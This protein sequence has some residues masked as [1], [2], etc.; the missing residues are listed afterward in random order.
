MFITHQDD[1]H[2]AFVEYLRKGTPIRLHTKQDQITGQW[3]ASF[4]AEVFSDR[5]NSEYKAP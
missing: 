1:D 5:T 3:T 4:I 2:R